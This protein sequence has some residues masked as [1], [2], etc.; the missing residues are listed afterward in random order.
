M[1]AGANKCA[2]MMTYQIELLEPK[3]KK[4]L[5]DLAELKLIRIRHLLNPRRP[6]GNFWPGCG[7]KMP[8]MTL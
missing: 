4:L 6:S 3:A 1:L 5:D 7:S 2:N 8:A